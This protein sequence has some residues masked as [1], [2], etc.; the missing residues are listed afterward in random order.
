[1]ERIALI[2]PVQFLQECSRRIVLALAYGLSNAVIPSTV[3]CRES[4]K[5]K[6]QRSSS[7]FVR[8]YNKESRFSLVTVST[9]KFFRIF[10]ASGCIDH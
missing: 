7:S 5:I 2:H 6:D 10:L 4:P 8:S 9:L 1:M 3:G